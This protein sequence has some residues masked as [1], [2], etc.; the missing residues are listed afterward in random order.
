MRRVVRLKQCGNVV[1]WPAR[2]VKGSWW[3]R[4][5]D[6]EWLGNSYAAAS[7]PVNTCM[8]QV[9]AERLGVIGMPR[10]TFGGALSGSRRTTIFP[11][12]LL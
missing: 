2:V 7:L 12:R 3:F 10:A 1:E 5:C 9:R 11:R 8:R 4:C 6:G